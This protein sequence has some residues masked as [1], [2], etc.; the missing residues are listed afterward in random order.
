MVYKLHITVEDI[1]FL[2]FYKKQ[3]QSPPSQDKNADLHHNTCSVLIHTRIQAISD[4]CNSI[5]SGVTRYV[6]T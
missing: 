1:D 6:S 3:S 2:N 4:Y 5:I